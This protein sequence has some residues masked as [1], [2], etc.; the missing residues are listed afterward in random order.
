[1]RHIR[2]LLRPPPPRAGDTSHS[3]SRSNMSKQGH[4]IATD[5]SNFN[6]VSFDEDLPGDYILVHNIHPI[7]YKLDFS[8]FAESKD[9]SLKNM[10]PDDFHFGDQS[11]INNPST[12]NEKGFCASSSFNNI[13]DSIQSSRIQEREF[14]TYITS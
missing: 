7:Y 4:Y 1:M 11:S 13:P 5:H 6:R 9:Y 12:V 3:R 14:K 10:V 2:N 8:K